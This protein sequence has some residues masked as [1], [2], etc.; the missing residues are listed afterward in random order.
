MV[1]G[2]D[3]E[4]V[5]Y[6][7]NFSVYTKGNSGS[8]DQTDDYN[9]QPLGQRPPPIRLSRLRLGSERSEEG[10]PVRVPGE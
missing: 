2:A 9:H 6:W 10:P 8:I 7:E 4:G 5:P 3:G 1:R